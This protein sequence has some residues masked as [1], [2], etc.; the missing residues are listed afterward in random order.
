M[1]K[2]V[3]TVNRTINWLDS[4]QIGIF[5]SRRKMIE[6]LKTEYDNIIFNFDET[7]KP[8][9]ATAIHKYF[10]KVSLRFERKRLDELSP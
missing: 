3:W 10:G 4:N 7:G 8:Y 2:C 9:Y 5:S 6:A 1:S